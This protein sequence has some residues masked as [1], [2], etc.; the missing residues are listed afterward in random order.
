MTA[1]IIIVLL[2]GIVF[3]AT[4]KPRHDLTSKAW[5]TKYDQHFR[6][7]TKRYFGPNV[8]W[9]WFKSQGIAESGLKG[10][11]R[12]SV[13]AIGVMQIMPGTFADIHKKSP[14]LSTGTLSD[15]RWNIASGIFYDRILYKRW[16]KKLINSTPENDLYM[17][18][19]SY[20]AGHG[21]ISSVLK[22]IKKQTGEAEGWEDIK[23][24][25]PSQTRHYVSRIKFLMGKDQ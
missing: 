6:K 2:P 25:V 13:G 17:T 1:L 23:N 5:T 18:F 3:A 14:Y 20:N 12:S 7:Y 21:R 9:R 16:K 15:P 8:D 24:K 4:S 22:K 11:A 19:A 10:S